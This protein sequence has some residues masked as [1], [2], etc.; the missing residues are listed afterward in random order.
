MK[1]IYVIVGALIVVAAV[2][3][4]IFNFQ[5]RSAASPEQTTTQPSATDPQHITQYLSDVIRAIQSYDNS[6]KEAN[7]VAQEYATKG[8]NLSNRNIKTAEET[9]VLMKQT[10][11]F[12]KGNSYLYPYLN[13]SNSLVSLTAQTISNSAASMLQPTEDMLQVIQNGGDTQKEQN[14]LAAETV[15]Q[16][17]GPNDMLQTVPIIT[18]GIYRQTRLNNLM[19]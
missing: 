8:I 18:K 14:D 15:A 17:K 4:V 2:T 11:D 1:R 7:I 3:G 6:T 12:K 19:R 5:N 13:D 9:A 10:N 16:D